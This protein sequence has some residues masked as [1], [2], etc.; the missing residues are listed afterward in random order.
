MGLGLG[1]G[2]GLEFRLGS[3][4]V[5]PPLQDL[6]PLGVEWVLLGERDAVGR[7]QR[8][9]KLGNEL[10]RTCLGLGS[11]LGLWVGVGLGLGQGVGVGVGLGLG[12]G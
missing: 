4:L 7:A 12:L 5:D 9:H 8:V 10:R 6:C 11:G 2:L 1:L 3:G